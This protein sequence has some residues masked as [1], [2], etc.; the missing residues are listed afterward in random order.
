MSQFPDRKS[1]AIKGNVTPFA[2]MARKLSEF[3]TLRVTPVELQE[4]KKEAGK[5]K[6]SALIRKKLFGDQD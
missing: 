5:Q 3:V 6:V 2:F 1:L 4:L